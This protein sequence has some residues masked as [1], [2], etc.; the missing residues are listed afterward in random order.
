[1]A[2]TANPAKRDRPAT[3]PLEERIHEDRKDRPEV[4]DKP[5]RKDP[6]VSRLLP[7]RVE[8]DLLDHRAHLDQRAMLVN[9][10]RLAHQADLENLVPTRN[11]ARARKEPPLRPPHWLEETD[12]NIFSTMQNIHFHFVGFIFLSPFNLI[13]F[14]KHK[15]GC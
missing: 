9:K 7:D 12:L 2:P 1:M 5:A 3:M 8:L 15:N 11:I 13:L 14:L 6:T 10:D 4:L